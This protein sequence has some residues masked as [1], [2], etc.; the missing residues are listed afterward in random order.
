MI[1][2]DE[3]LEFDWDKGNQYKSLLKHGVTTKEIE[4][5]F[6][7]DP[8]TTRE[9]KKHSQKERRFKCMGKTNEGRLLFIVFTLRNNKIRAISARPMS[10]KERYIYEKA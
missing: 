10:E 5:A 6:A 7:N 8:F 3:N 1:I 9:D 2:L 4:R